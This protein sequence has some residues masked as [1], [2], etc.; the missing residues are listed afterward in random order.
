MCRELRL[1]EPT[2]PF[3]GEL[4]AVR[5][6]EPTGKARPSGCCTASRCPARPRAAL[7]RG[8]RLDRRPPPGGPA[9]VLPGPGPRAGSAASPAPTGHP[10]AGRQLDIKDTPF[11]P[12]LERELARRADYACVETMAEFRRREPGRSPRPARSRSRRHGTRRTTADRIDDR[13]HYVLGWYNERKI[14]ALLGQAERWHAQLADARPASRPQDEQAREPRRDRGH[15]LTRLDEYPRLRRHRLAAVVN[16]IAELQS[17]RARARG[18]VVELA[19]TDPRAGDGAAARS[20]LARPR[21][22]AQTGLGSIGHRIGGAEAELADGERGSADRSA[23]RPRRHF[24]ALAADSTGAT[25]DAR[26]ADAACR[27]RRRCRLPAQSR[28]IDRRTQRRTAR[29]E[30][31]VATMAE[32][33]SQ[34]P[35]ETAGVRRLGRRGRRV[36]RTAPPAGRRRP[37]AVRGRVQDL[38][39]SEHDPRHRQLPLPAEQAARTDQG[40]DR[41]HQ[42]IAGR[43]RLQPRPLHPAGAAADPEHRR[44]RLPRRPAGLHRRRAV[45]RRRPTSTRS[46]S[47]CRSSR[48]SSGSRAARARPRPTGRGPRVTDVRNWFIFSASERWRDDDTEYE[49]YTDSGGKSGGQK[50]KLAYT[51]L[52][53]SLAYQFKLDWG[54][55][56]SRTSAS[57]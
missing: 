34:Y 32:F 45:R 38:P 40:A 6:D 57:W 21:R 29:G 49:N 36:P 3:A 4:I 56:K 20:A 19:A 30:Q 46:R 24:A 2:L 9:G 31:I 37:A 16:R 7:R 52:A 12:W 17:E 14:D 1:A 48:S 15:V 10:C 33:R 11:A 47:S 23:S 18:G 26:H 43:H 55:A 28:G 5:D 27:P 22:Q 39:E 42:R 44:P 54:A 51:I 35:L 25:S 41:H 53:A 8:S 13:R 50:E